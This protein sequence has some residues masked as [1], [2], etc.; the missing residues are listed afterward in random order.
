MNTGTSIVV[1]KSC[2]GL[3][4]RHRRSPP[5][6]GDGAQRGV[7]PSTN[8]REG[9]PPRLLSDEV[10]MVS[11]GGTRYP[12]PPQYSSPD[13]GPGPDLA[14]PLVPRATARTPPVLRRGRV[15]QGCGLRV[16]DDLLPPAPG[17]SPMPCLMVRAGP[18]RGTRCLAPSLWGVSM[19][20]GVT[21]PTRSGC[22]P[23]SATTP[24]PM[25]HH[26]KVAVFATGRAGPVGQ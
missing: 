14:C 13:L 1:A 6:A 4:V 12:L 16:V 23:A 8:A 22:G 3:R 17:Q 21:W 24:S 26:N 19:T 11:R 10:V 20:A 18:P 9:L 25:A 7:R 5:V 2:Q 15:L